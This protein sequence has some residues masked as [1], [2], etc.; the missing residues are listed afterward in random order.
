MNC[1][2]R[3]KILVL[4]V[5]CHIIKFNVFI[6][7]L[8]R[9]DITTMYHLGFFPWR[10]QRPPRR[11]GPLH[12]TLTLHVAQ[13][14]VEENRLRPSKPDSPCHLKWNHWLHWS[15]AILASPG[16]SARI[17]LH[18][19]HLKIS[20]FSVSHLVLFL[21]TVT[22]CQCCYFCQKRLFL[23]SRQFSLEFL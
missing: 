7:P 21:G 20:S 11:P 18:V 15:Q 9:V 13:L 1:H 3:F 17:F 4:I 8:A 6:H 22:F 2:Q 12:F 19:G 23:F 14:H 16:W 10:L 5:S